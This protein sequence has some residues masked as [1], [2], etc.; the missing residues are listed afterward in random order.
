MKNLKK[1]WP[2]HYYQRQKEEIYKECAENIFELMRSILNIEDK[3]SDS[4][5]IDSNSELN[6]LIEWREIKLITVKSII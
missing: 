2:C 4:D 5:S 1:V 6:N 3:E